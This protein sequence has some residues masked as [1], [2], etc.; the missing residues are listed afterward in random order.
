MTGSAQHPDDSGDW[1]KSHDLEEIEDY[2]NSL[3]NLVL[4]SKSKNS[5]ASNYDFEKKE[6]KYLSGR[7]SI[8]PRSVQVLKYDEW[9]KK[10]IE[11]RTEEAAELLVSDP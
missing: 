2:V 5:S 3:G 6:Q 4:L 1:A 11:E 7:V 10:V 8:F 9:T